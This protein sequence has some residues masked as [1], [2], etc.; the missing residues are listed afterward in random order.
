MGVP[1][2]RKLL[3]AAA[4]LVVACATNILDLYNQ[5]R[6]KVMAPP[7]PVPNDW[8][9]D[10]RLKLADGTV[11]RIAR[12][13]V[14]HGL[15]QRVTPIRL[16]TPV[17]ADV[18]VAPNGK[19]TRLHIAPSNACDGC[20]EVDARL[21]GKVRWTAGPLSGKVPFSASFDAS[22]SFA[23]ERRDRTW[24]IAAQ[25]ADVRDIQVQV[26]GRAASTDPTGSV[27]RWVDQA[28]ARVPP[29]KLG[30]FGG[31]QL[32]ILAL[33]FGSGAGASIE[34]QALTDV[35]SPSAV[36]APRSAPVTDWVLRIAQNSVLA[37]ARRAAFRRGPVAYDVAVD[38]RSL[39]L[40]DQ[41]F[42][43]GL[44]LWRL[45]GLGWWRDYSVTGEVSVR[46][47]RIELWPEQATAGEKSKGAGI[48][49]PI[50]LLAEGRILQAV[51][52]GVRQALPGSQAT[53]AGPLRFT[54]QA[55]S[56]RGIGDALVIAGNATVR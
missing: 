5:E 18:E 41:T 31:D 14:N 20:L 29:V 27:R 26:A 19:V 17:G 54:A 2:S 24:T 46:G 43:L 12:T 23:A 10:L 50:A 7:P 21:N 37:L 40:Q 53:Q 28:L 49:D 6:S 22:L 11:A 45:K 48:A 15:V 44:R 1:R 55:V 25:L 13:A 32:P 16:H 52:D 51:S 8:Q 33:R 42:T 30:S 47:N 34:I 4:I 9:P 36:S 56:V 38:P 3:M 39:H 35:P